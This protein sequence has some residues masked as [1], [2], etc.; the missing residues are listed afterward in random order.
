MKYVRLFFIMLAGN[1][2]AHYLCK[3][4]DRHVINR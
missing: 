3:W 4:L 2:I 1:L